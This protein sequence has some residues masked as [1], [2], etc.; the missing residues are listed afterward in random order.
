MLFFVTK[1]LISFLSVVVTDKAAYVAYETMFG[2]G[3]PEVRPRLSTFNSDWI[4]ERTQ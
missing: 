1:R 3:E 2:N 4:R